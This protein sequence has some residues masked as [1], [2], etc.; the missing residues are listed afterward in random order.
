MQQYN[1]VQKI[2]YLDSRPERK[3]SEDV[4]TLGQVY[5]KARNVSDH[6]LKSKLRRTY[7]KAS[8]EA[9]ENKTNNASLE[10]MEHACKAAVNFG[11][12]WAGL[13]MGTDDP[14]D[15]IEGALKTSAE[16]IAAAAYSTKTMSPDEEKQLQNA[17][18]HASWFS[19][20]AQGFALAGGTKLTRKELEARSNL[21]KYLGWLNSAYELYKEKRKN[22]RFSNGSI[23]DVARTAVTELGE[24]GCEYAFSQTSTT[25]TS[26]VK[27]PESKPSESPSLSDSYATS[28]S[29]TDQFSVAPELMH[30]YMS[31][32]EQWKRSINPRRIREFKIETRSEKAARGSNSDKYHLG[33]VKH[34]FDR[35]MDEKMDWADRIHEDV[36]RAKNRN[37]PHKKNIEKPLPLQILFRGDADHHDFGEREIFAGEP[38]HG[39]SGTMTA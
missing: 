34:D 17:L 2:R 12:L 15:L 9:A 11:S 32:V 8:L 19:I 7:D 4:T 6:N 3:S 21:Q 30:K 33:D 16:L 5:S 36:E 1:R 35:N 37:S 25:P 38:S 28:T 22:S 27:T 14:L 31:D 24:K 13:E 29:S 39:D 26:I 10:A 18:A 20:F 23:R